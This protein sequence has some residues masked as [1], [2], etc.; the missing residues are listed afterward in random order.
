[1]KQLRWQ[2]IIVVLGLI[3]IGVLLISQQPAIL[4]GVES[5]F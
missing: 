2:I 5:V 1:M 4:P 3:A